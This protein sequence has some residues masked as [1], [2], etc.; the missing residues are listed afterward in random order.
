MESTRNGKAARSEAEEV[1]QFTCLMGGPANQRSCS[2]T[3]RS[4][5]VWWAGRLAMSDL[6]P[7]MSLVRVTAAPM[8]TPSAPTC[9]GHGIA[10]HSISTAQHSTAHYK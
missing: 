4:V 1:A 9:S 10:W 2:S 3:A 5:E 8:V 7:P 6:N